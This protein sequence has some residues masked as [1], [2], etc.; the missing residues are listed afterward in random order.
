[1]QGREGVVAVVD[2]TKESVCVWWVD[3]GLKPNQSMSRLCGA[4]V[5]A[6]GDDK[7][8]ESLTFARIVLPTKAGALALQSAGV[9]PDRL[10]DPNA[11]VAAATACRDRCQQAFETEQ[12][13]RT[14][15]KRLQAPGWPAFPATL[16]VEH[17]PAWDA[18]GRPDDPLV[19]TALSIAHWL[20]ALCGR[21]EQLEEQRLSR[22]LLRALDGDNERPLPV[23]LV[24]AS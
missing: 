8:L 19:D 16:D 6:S 22:T 21:W 9:S 2:A 20:D 14:P 4:W 24:E 1:M 10:L 17:P 12:A 23:V 15:S 11:T 18:N 7:T 3:A 13:R 5:L